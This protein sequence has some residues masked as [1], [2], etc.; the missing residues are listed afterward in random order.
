MHGL[1]S[2]LDFQA[3]ALAAASGT[4]LRCRCLCATQLKAQ[5]I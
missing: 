4:A 2:P 5:V 1:W 3:G